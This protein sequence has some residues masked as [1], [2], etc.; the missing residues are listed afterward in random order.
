MKH[1][2]TIKRLIAIFI[3]LCICIVAYGVFRT[4]ESRDQAFRSDLIQIDSSLN[5]IEQYGKAYLDGS[6]SE[7]GALIIREL[8]HISTA[9][10]SIYL[11]QNGIPVDLR[12]KLYDYVDELNGTFSILEPAQ[13]KLC[14]QNILEAV[15]S[16]HPLFDDINSIT[17]HTFAKE[18]KIF[19]DTLFSFSFPG[20]TAD[21]S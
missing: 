2:K 16:F 10:D 15:K 9:V 17:T 3:P 12:Q 20:K 8:S 7:T 14:I 1:A 19:I 5:V 11:N 18:A 13:K 4:R 21:G 6:S